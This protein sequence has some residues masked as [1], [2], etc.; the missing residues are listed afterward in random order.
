MTTFKHLAC[1]TSICC[2]ISLCNTT[3]ANAST[4]SFSLPLPCNDA[5]HNCENEA[6]NYCTSG[7][8]IV[9]AA[10]L[11]VSYPSMQAQCEQNRQICMNNTY[12]LSAK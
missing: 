2:V 1:L 12:P 5:Y 7:N 3:Y 4:S 10:C 6:W 9:S 8:P 11:T